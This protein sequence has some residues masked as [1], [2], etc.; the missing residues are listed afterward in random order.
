[1][2]CSWRLLFGWALPV[3]IVHYRIS[4]SIL[5]RIRGNEVGVSQGAGKLWMAAWRPQVDLLSRRYSVLDYSSWPAESG[6]MDKQVNA[7]HVQRCRV[8]YDIYM[9][10]Y[11]HIY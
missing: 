11:M 3:I 7:Y 6:H 9:L 5:V 10:P 8:Q 4:L 2:P 1:M